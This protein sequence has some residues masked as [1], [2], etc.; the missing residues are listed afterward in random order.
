MIVQAWWSICAPQK[1]LLQ[2]AL[3][4]PI[5]SRN[6][7]TPTR[8]QPSK[9]SQSVRCGACV[10][11]CWWLHCV[12]KHLRSL[13]HGGLLHHALARA[14]L[15]QHTPKSSKCTS[16]PCYTHMHP[17]CIHLA[18]DHG[19][20]ALPCHLLVVRHTTKACGGKTPAHKRSTWLPA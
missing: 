13:Y 19:L 17:T 14:V 8:T 10:I 15:K 9:C 20:V 1:T 2:Q 4:A 5:A 6:T 3:L 16:P 7:A 18:S 12:P 11:H